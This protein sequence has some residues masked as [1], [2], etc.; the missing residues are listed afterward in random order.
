M[1]VK[2]SSITLESFNLCFVSFS[3]CFAGNQSYS[4]ALC[5]NVIKYIQSPSL[6]LL[7]CEKV[8]NKLLN[9]T[10]LITPMRIH[11]LMMAEKIITAKTEDDD[12]QPCPSPIADCSQSSQ[13]KYPCMDKV[14]KYVTSHMS[15]REY[16]RLLHGA[17]EA[18][19]KTFHVRDIID[20]QRHIRNGEAITDATLKDQLAKEMERRDKTKESKISFV[21]AKINMN[22]MKRSGKSLQGLIFPNEIINDKLLSAIEL[23][24]EPAQSEQYRQDIK[25]HDQIM[26]QVA[27]AENNYFIDWI[28]KTK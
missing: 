27:V 23:A 18:Y 15:R 4:T 21:A 22:K 7:I 11:T 9:S 2:L 17:F 10:E 8:V 20:T 14:H 25:Y 6:K 19:L 16:I 12:E 1:Y 5:T 24:M 26:H 3:F 13:N 28:V